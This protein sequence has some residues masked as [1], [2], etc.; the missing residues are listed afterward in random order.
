MSASSSTSTF[1]PSMPNQICG[2][3]MCI[4]DVD[5]ILRSVIKEFY[6]AKYKTTIVGLLRRNPVREKI[7]SYMTKS[8]CEY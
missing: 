6:N 5:T 7:V 8:I 1:S 4:Q 3:D 2:G